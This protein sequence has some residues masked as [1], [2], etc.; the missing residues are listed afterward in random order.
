MSIIALAISSGHFGRADVLGQAVG[1]F[2]VVIVEAGLGL[3][4]G[5]RKRL[6]AEHRDGQLAALDERLGEQ[7][8]EMLPRALRT[9]RPI[10]IAV[11]AV[12]R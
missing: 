9:S 11:I 8:V 12:R 3:Q 1:I 6:V 10:G 5:D 4:L 7:V 2:G